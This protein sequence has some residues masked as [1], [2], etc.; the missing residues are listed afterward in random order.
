MSVDSMSPSGGSRRLICEEMEHSEGP[1]SAGARSAT[2]KKLHTK[3]DVED[4]VFQWQ[5]KRLK[6]FCLLNLPITVKLLRNP[7]TCHNFADRNICLISF[8]VVD[9]REYNGENYVLGG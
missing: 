7:A 2:L 4:H 6:L 9:A 3:P 5:P 1:T 8:H